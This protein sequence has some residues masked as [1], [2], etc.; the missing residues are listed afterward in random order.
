LEIGQV[1]VKGFPVKV[2]DFFTWNSQ[3]DPAALV[4]GVGQLKGGVQGVFHRQILLSNI[5]LSV[6]TV[7]RYVLTDLLEEGQYFLK[8]AGEQVWSLMRL[9]FRLG[10]RPVELQVAHG[11]HMK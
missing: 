1:K 10:F 11:S 5:F 3:A 9:F 6:R 8:K 2:V 4:A 7:G